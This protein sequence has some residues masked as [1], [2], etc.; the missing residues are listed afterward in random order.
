M[1]DLENALKGIAI[2]RGADEDGVVVEM[3]KY[4]S[5]SF[6]ES[7]LYVFNRALSDGSCDES[8]HTVILQ[9]LSKKTNLKNYQIVLS[10]NRQDDL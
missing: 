10:S 7:L 1:E 2:L 9:M 8:W 4:S 3:I 6:K 5:I